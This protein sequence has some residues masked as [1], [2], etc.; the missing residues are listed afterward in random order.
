[1]ADY[2]ILETPNIDRARVAFHYTVPPAETNAVGKL[3]T[4]A[5]NEHL[6]GSSRANV[7]QVPW[8][9]A[10]NPT[11][12]ADIQSGAT[13]EHVTTVYFDGNAS[14]AE[15]QQII[16]DTHDNIGSAVLNTMRE[17]LKFWGYDGTV[18]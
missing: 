5:V 7:T 6:G 3:L 18:P 15:K 14:N 12:Y 8:L 17:K 4:E 1:M 11:E 10:T 16:E 2:H 9:Q 13:Y